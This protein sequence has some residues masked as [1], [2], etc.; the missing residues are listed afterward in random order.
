MRSIPGDYAFLSDQH[1]LAYLIGSHCFRIRWLHPRWNFCRGAETGWDRFKI[2]P[3]KYLPG[4]H[5]GNLGNQYFLH[6]FKPW[7]RL[8]QQGLSQCEPTL[9]AENVYREALQRWLALAQ[10]LYGESYFER[11]VGNDSDLPLH[12]RAHDFLVHHFSPIPSPFPDSLRCFLSAVMIPPVAAKALLVRE[13]RMIHNF[14]AARYPAN[15]TPTLVQRFLPCLS[16]RRLILRCSG[17]RRA[18]QCAVVKT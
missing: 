11:A 17:A 15:L 1:L 6:L 8:T 2:L 16:M 3:R 14:T 4:S 10:E 12:L 13:I 7:E 18:R 5:V 9:S